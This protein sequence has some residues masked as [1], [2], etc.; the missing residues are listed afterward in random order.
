MKRSEREKGKTET[1]KEG[2]KR[3]NKYEHV[4]LS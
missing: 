4:S 1:R 2:R 3:I